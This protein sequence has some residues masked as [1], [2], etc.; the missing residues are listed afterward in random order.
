V[1]A[2][3]AVLKSHAQLRSAPL[4]IV[5]RLAEI[6]IQKQV[7]ALGIAYDALSI[8]AELGIVRGEEK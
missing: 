5:V 8:T 4:R 1:I 3:S 7:L 6:P 2:K